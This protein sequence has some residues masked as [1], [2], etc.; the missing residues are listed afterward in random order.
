M[1]TGS[2]RETERRDRLFRVAGWI[3]DPAACRLEKNGQQAR[4][5]PKVMQ[6][7]EYLVE[8]VGQVVS[9]QELEQSVWSGTVVGYEAVTNA[10]IKLRKALGDDAR[11][12]QIIETISKHGYRLVAD[13]TPVSQRISAHRSG[14]KS[15]LG[16]TALLS[17]LVIAGGLTWFFP[18]KPDVEP[19]SIEDMAFPLPS[20]IPTNSRELCGHFDQAG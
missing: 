11:N 13:V 20:G 12:P 1:S 6:V 4:I 2:P 10:I 7:L 18:D 16:L 17:L 5:E 9:R 8:H 3:A 19:A 15:S 14:R